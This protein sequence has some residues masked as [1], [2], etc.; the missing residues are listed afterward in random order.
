ML[1][2]AIPIIMLNARFPWQT[3]S[4][5]VLGVCGTDSAVEILERNTGQ[6]PTSMGIE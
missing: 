6:L 2:S 5:N 1:S 3:Q 4:S